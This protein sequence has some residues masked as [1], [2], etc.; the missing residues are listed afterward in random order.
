MTLHASD[1]NIKKMSKI[2][3]LWAHADDD[4]GAELSANV[5]PHG[6]VM[7]QVEGK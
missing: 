7:L 5:P 4:A 3:D 6:V 2:R 1:L